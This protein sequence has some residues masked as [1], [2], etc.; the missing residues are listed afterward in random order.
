[1]HVTGSRR[2]KPGYLKIRFYNLRGD[3]VHAQSATLFDRNGTDTS[4]KLG[5]VEVDVRQGMSSEDHKNFDNF[6]FT[7]EVYWKVENK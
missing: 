4:F 6:D 2:A 5:G 7:F 1:M 3:K